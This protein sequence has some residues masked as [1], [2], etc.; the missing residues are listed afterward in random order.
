[1]AASLP[2]PHRLSSFL[3]LLIV[4]AACTTAA[5]RA[6]AQ[7]FGANKV[8]YRTFDFQVLQTE[9]FDI[10]F[11][12]EEQR[13]A[14]MASRLSERWRARLGRVLRHELTGR[15]PLILY[16][17]HPHFEQTNAIGGAIGESTGGVTEGIRRR[18]VLPLG[19]SLADSDHVIGHELVHAYQF[20][21]TTA[22]QAGGQ[23]GMPGA[24]RLPLWF[25]EGMAE[26]LSIGPVDP[27]TA[28][29]IRDAALG[30][31]LPT[32]RDLNNPE[33]FPYRWGQAFWSYVAGRWGEDIVGRLLRS[34]ARAGSAEV[35][36]ETDLGMKLE[37][38]SAEWHAALRRMA[39]QV[40]DETAAA[41]RFGDRLTEPQALGGEVNI[42]P[43]LSPDGRRLAFL[44]ERELFSI[45]LYIA[46]A[47]TGEII[48]QVSETSVDPHFTSL[49][50]INSSGSWSPTGD[51]LAFAAITHGRAA[52]AI[53]DVERR[54]VTQEIRLEG[55]DEAFS[56][57]WSPDGRA[58]AFSGM[59][60]GF[61]DLF[62]VTLE[63][64]AVR[65]LTEDA[66][67]DLQPVWSPD[68]RRIAFATDRFT[69][70]LAT[71][72]AGPYRLA[73]VEPG[74][75]RIEEVP[76]FPGAKHINPQWSPDGES[77]Y[78]L[79]D[80]GGITNAYRVHLASGELRQSTNL[81]TGISG[82][83]ASSPALSVAQQAGRM[84]FTV[85]E[86]G[87]H[88]IYASERPEVLAGSAVRELPA[89]SAAVLPPPVRRDAPLMSLLDNQSMG[90]PQQAS[91]DV[92][93]YSPGLQLDAV[94]SPS[95]SVG[96]DRFGTF[97]GGGVAFSFSDVLGD[98]NLGA[99]VQFT[100]S[101]TGDTSWKDFGGMV[102]YTNLRRRWNWGGFVEQSPY[103]SGGFASGVGIIEG[104][105]A[106]VEQSV[107]YRQTSRSVG[108]AAAYPFSRAQRLEFSAGYRNLSFDRDVRLTAYSQL[109][110]DVIVDERTSESFGEPL[111]LAEASAALVYDTS[112]FG[113]TSPVL[114]QR[115]RFEVSPV[116]GTLAFTNVTADFR[117][118]VM[119]A[120]FYTLATRVMHYG[121]YG[122]DSEDARLMPLFLGYPTL[123]RGY[124]IGS[125]TN[126]DCPP[127]PSGRCEAIDSLVGSR[128]VVA[129]VELRFPLLRPFGMQRGLY[130]PVPVEV[131]LFA[132]GG[133][134]WDS[135]DRPEVFGGDREPVSSAGIALRVNALGFAVVEFDFVRPFQR[136][137]RGWMFQFSLA[138]GF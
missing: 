21:I 57:T 13:A 85:Y 76:G 23:G 94:G 81:Q 133:V 82:I 77:L 18:I 78:F 73:L 71:L 123:V 135:G 129:N 15:Q 68:G 56:P 92:K 100:S 60:G 24:L 32:I 107:I 136:D 72:A 3:A 34:A 16:A 64:G 12:P 96:R 29:W 47:Q 63:S 33:Y 75:A 8:Q 91:R 108:A 9:H 66:F 110:G 59:S 74:S 124:D 45:D 27:H 26:Y 25:V 40:T 115:Y 41:S 11:Y 102:A 103:R 95:V 137:G 130:G 70:S 97:G 79:S 105:P 20:D 39:D 134:A 6:E 67:A 22:R 65:R 2:G 48:T 89:A 84:A 42:A 31:K 51:R 101:I 90:L 19:A 54:S 93:D 5:R 62:V 121:R 122:R 119:P 128:M 104:E 117:R 4:A 37:E 106:Y 138:P 83:T 50:F 46:D 38:L 30:E 98:H 109:T 53:Y 10:Y 61:T 55:V 69:T 14:E 88:R 80:R 120:Q 43:S 17:A 58:V 111:D 1:M 7:Y 52:L 112:I 86:N 36:L 114:G 28:L 131:A 49:Q 99:A 44:S 35:A 118:Y 116:A 125:F 126:E 87:A 127:D 113:A 132:D